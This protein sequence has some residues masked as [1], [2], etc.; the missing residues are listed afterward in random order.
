MLQVVFPPFKNWGL[1]TPR[2][3]CRLK[4]NL[5]TETPFTTGVDF[6]TREEKNQG[7]TLNLLHL[8]TGWLIAG[9]SR[10]S[11]SKLY[12]FS[13]PEIYQFFQ[14]GSF[15]E[16]VFTSIITRKNVHIS[17]FLWKPLPPMSEIKIKTY[18][19]LAPNVSAPTGDRFSF[20]HISFCY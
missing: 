3:C 19:D 7:L 17:F 5:S 18:M 2:S 14:A 10:D 20:L 9:L 1:I 6:W 11:Q 8:R 13:S 12:N 16:I 4:V 15:N